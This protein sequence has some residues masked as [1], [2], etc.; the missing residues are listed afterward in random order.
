M[1]QLPLFAFKALSLLPALKLFCNQAWFNAE[2]K[3]GVY[4]L[5]LTLQWLV[6]L[7]DAVLLVLSLL[8]IVTSGPVVAMLIAPAG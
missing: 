7:C 4:C 1:H 3:A 2:A 6:L 5:L 8:L